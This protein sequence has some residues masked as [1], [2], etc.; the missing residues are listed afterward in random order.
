V[1]L[2]EDFSDRTVREIE[3]RVRAVKRPGDIVVASIHWGGNWGHDL[4]RAHTLFARRLIDEAAV[5]VIHGHSSHHPQGIEVYRDRPILYGCGDFLNDYEG[6]SGH[7]A[8]RS[9]LALMYFVS[10]APST[11]KLVR[12]EMTPTQTKRFRLNRASAEDARWLRDTLD[13]E[14]RRFG[15]RVDL[16]QTDTLALRWGEGLSPPAI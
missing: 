3:E 14:S 5:D 1:N 9:D 12:L 6:I 15:V 10:L 4:P 2:L 11:G 13:R 7:E 16:T 8:Y